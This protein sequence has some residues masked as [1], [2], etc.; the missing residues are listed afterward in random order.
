MKHLTTEM[1]PFGGI[2]KVAWEVTTG[3]QSLILFPILKVY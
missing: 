1:Q 3:R 2:G